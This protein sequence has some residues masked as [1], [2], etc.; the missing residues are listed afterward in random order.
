MTPWNHQSFLDIRPP[1][2]LGS[3]N[4]VTATM[5]LP[6]GW[7]TQLH[8]DQGG[9]LSCVPVLGTNPHK[10]VTDPV[11]HVDGSGVRWSQV[12]S[13]ISISVKGQ[14]RALFR[15]QVS[16]DER[17]NSAL[18]QNLLEQCRSYLLTRHQPV[19]RETEWPFRRAALAIHHLHDRLAPSV[20]IKSVGL[21]GKPLDFGQ[22]CPGALYVRQ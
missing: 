3:S 6:R 18:I 14:D 2:R 9:R 7:D 21:D 13:L 1:N 15:M 10:W 11:Q 16:V 22:P 17:L 12:A 8:W 20:K 4:W 5:S 19:T